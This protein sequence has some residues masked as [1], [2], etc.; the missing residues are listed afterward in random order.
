MA[1]GFN[2]SESWEP[3]ETIAAD[4]ASMDAAVGMNTPHGQP[5]VYFVAGIKGTDVFVWGADEVTMREHS[6]QARLLVHDHHTVVDAMACFEEIVAMAVRSGL[7]PDA[8]HGVE[9]T[10]VTVELPIPAVHTLN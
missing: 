1:H 6:H 8:A 10:V 9:L 5:P 3:F 4:Q 2:L 7:V